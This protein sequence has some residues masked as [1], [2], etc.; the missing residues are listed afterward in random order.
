MMPDAASLAA[1][2]MADNRDKQ[3]LEPNDVPM[4]ISPSSDIIDSWPLISIVIPAFNEE[5]NIPRLEY[6]LL[7]AVDTLPYRFEFIVI[8]ND[9]S[10]STGD[11]VKAICRR[12]PRWGYL[13]FSRNFTVE[14]SI[15]A[16]YHYATGDAI[17][18]LYSDLQDPPSAIPLLLSKWQ[19]GY[20][21]VYGVPSVRS[22]DPAWRKL[23][24]KLAYRLIAWSAEVPIPTDT[25]DFRLVTRQVRDALARCNEYNRYTR[26]LIA[27]LGF[28][29]TGIRYERRARKAGVSKAP[30]W[31]TIFITVNA[32][33]SFSLKPLRVFTF[34][35]FIMIGIS[36]LA[37]L[38]YLV[39]FFIG[40]PLPGLTTLVFLAI[41]SI[42]FNSAGI[43]IMGEYLGRTYFE[44]KR[45]PL[46]VVHESFNMSK[47]P[48]KPDAMDGGVASGWDHSKLGAAE[49]VSLDGGLARAENV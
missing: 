38:V 44:S 16:G 7:G 42:G 17:I 24:A 4:Q 46:Y 43:G 31:H 10:D 23:A 45:R 41:F 14:M 18:V 34:F 40:S 22:G 25:G 21:V 27:W 30:L 15:T 3:G 11:L 20:D 37:M 35:G 2:S 13:K 26:G 33:T 12:D 47:R 49:G 5:D 28:R 9:S 1:A 19:E 48:M 32:M 29:Q 36:I 8:D 6:E 39:L